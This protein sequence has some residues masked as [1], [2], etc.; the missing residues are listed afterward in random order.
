[1]REFPGLCLVRSVNAACAQASQL[2]RPA[3]TSPPHPSESQP[4]QPRTLST[5]PSSS[6]CRHDSVRTPPHIRTRVHGHTHALFVPLYSHRH[7]AFPRPT[8][9]PSFP[10][11]S[12][13]SSVSATAILAPFSV[14]PQT[15]TVSV[16]RTCPEMV[17]LSSPALGHPPAGKTP[18]C[19][20]PPQLYAL[21]NG[22]LCSPLLRL[23]EIT[24]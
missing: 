15:L 18:Q 23:P 9:R 19:S 4:T 3:L 5:R 2:M 11:C 17:R 6:G 13:L 14:R 20:S 24:S 22:A 21:P 16:P 7:I 10:H 8:R 12:S 1:M